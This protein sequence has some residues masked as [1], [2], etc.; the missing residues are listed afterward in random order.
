MSQCLK[1]VVP[2]CVKSGRQFSDKLFIKDPLVDLEAVH[3]DWKS[4]GFFPKAP[5]HVVQHGAKCLQTQLSHARLN[6]HVLGGKLYRMF[7]LHAKYGGLHIDFGTMTTPSQTLQPPQVEWSSVP[8]DPD[9]KYSMIIYSPDCTICKIHWWVCNIR[10]DHL[11]SP[12]VTADDVTADDVTVLP[13]VPAVPL[14]GTGVYRYVLLLLEQ[15]STVTASRTDRLSELSSIID[16]HRLLPV[17][18]ALY[19]SFWDDT[20][21]PSLASCLGL[22][23]QQFSVERP[24]DVEEFYAEERFLR[25]EWEMKTDFM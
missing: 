3:K 1:R 16:E 21:G 25:K 4:G 14:K 7:P 18:L 8:I 12:D 11:Q 23:E 10:P 15:D 13:Y 20:V 5:A 24:K 22:D 17:G 2:L 19:Q 9:K 6:N